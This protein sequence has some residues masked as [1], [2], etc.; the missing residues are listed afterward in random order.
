MW[1]MS[2]SVAVLTTFLAAQT[3][4]AYATDGSLQGAK[5]LFYTETGTTVAPKTDDRGPT[6][7]PLQLH[8]DRVGKEN[9]SRASNRSKTSVTGVGVSK[10]PW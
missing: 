9:V 4:L 1:R 7:P 6:T 2:W 3:W 8:G 10:E 5:A